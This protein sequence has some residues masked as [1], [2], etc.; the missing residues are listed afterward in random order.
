MNRAS[1][2]EAAPALDQVQE[3]FPYGFVQVKTMQFYR[4][5]FSN[6]S[7]PNHES[8]KE[9]VRKYASEDDSKYRRVPISSVEDFKELY[10]AWL[11]INKLKVQV[12]GEEWPFTQ[13]DGRAMTKKEAKRLNAL[14]TEFHDVDVIMAEENPAANLPDRNDNN[15]SNF[16]LAQE[17][18][19]QTRKRKTTSDDQTPPAASPRKRVKKSMKAPAEMSRRSK[20]IDR[21]A[22]KN[23]KESIE[24]GE[25]HPAPK[26]KPVRGEF[27]EDMI[28]EE[29]ELA[30]TPKN[31]QTAFQS[32]ITEPPVPKQGLPGTPIAIALP[33]DVR[34]T[35]FEANEPE[36]HP[37]T[38]AAES[39]KSM[40]VAATPNNRVENV[41]LEQRLETASPRSEQEASPSLTR[42]AAL[43]PEQ[44][45]RPT[46]PPATPTPYSQ[47][48]KSAQLPGPTAVPSPELMVAPQSPLIPAPNVRTAN[49]GVTIEY[50]TTACV[51][52]NNGCVHVY[53][54][55]AW[56]GDDAMLRKY[57]EYLQV[58][59]AAVVTFEQFSSIM[60]FRSGGSGA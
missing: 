40:E 4:G 43:S 38:A 9:C 8:M 49:S 29:P 58:P 17:H 51:K 13:D 16:G 24:L 5:V 56:N 27:D 59:D 55:S 2:L 33:L 41:D 34:P 15:S 1:S 18:I 31:G 60:A 42:T 57:A 26:A 50:F 28:E 21:K 23:Q 6:D 7:N 48:S 47:Q 22:V 45:S 32:S 11:R 53:L 54:G 10:Q 37:T 25:T 14:G 20:R 39:P 3:E 19:E 12:L 36:E 30:Q 44:A 46:P 35:S 52:T